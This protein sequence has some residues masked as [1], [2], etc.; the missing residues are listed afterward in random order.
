MPPRG[1]KVDRL[2]EAERKIAELQ[3]QLARLE[4][5]PANVPSGRRGRMLGKLDGTL[6]A[7]GTQTVDGEWWDG[8]AVGTKDVSITARDYFLPTGK[9]L[10]DE[11]KVIAEFMDDAEWWITAFENQ[12]VAAVLFGLTTAAV[13]SGDSTFNVDGVVV[14]SPT[15]GVSPGS[16]INGVFNILR[17]P[18]LNNAETLIFRQAETDTYYGIPRPDRGSECP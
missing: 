3:R 6:T 1:S 17:F 14:L 8:A 10:P 4:A 12:G 5:R 18:A 15:G 13:T 11:A 16:T 2:S 9:T 7:G